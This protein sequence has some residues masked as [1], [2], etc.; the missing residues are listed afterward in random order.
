MQVRCGS[1]ILLTP[2]LVLAR[3]VCV[4]PEVLM[5]SLSF[6]A[7][8]K[9]AW[10]AIPNQGNRGSQFAVA[11]PSA[12]DLSQQLLS[13]IYLVSALQLH[14]RVHMPTAR[15]EHQ[16]ARCVYH[17][18]ICTCTAPSSA[19]CSAPNDCAAIRI[20]LAAIAV[21]VG[22]HALHRRLHWHWRRVHCTWRLY[23][24]R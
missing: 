12:S 18:Y 7:T 15:G 14:Q 20:S 11:T 8:A 3:I 22:E 9:Q 4:L 6:S 16:T 23:Q 5:S 1:R 17:T 24:G 10:T 13:M 19:G 21:D 2:L